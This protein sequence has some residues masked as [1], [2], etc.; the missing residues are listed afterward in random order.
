MEDRLVHVTKNVEENVKRVARLGRN[1]AR[2]G[3]VAVD[4]LMGTDSI[5][6]AKDRTYQGQN[7]KT[8]T[9]SETRLATGS[10]R[11]EL[12]REHKLWINR[13]LHKIDPDP[14]EEGEKPG[15]HVRCADRIA[16]FDEDRKSLDGRHPP[17]K[18]A[19][20]RRENIDKVVKRV[21]GFIGRV[22][23]REE[24]KSFKA[25]NQ[26][27]QNL[28]RRND[29]RHKCRNRIATN[30]AFIPR[31]EDYA[32]PSTVTSFVHSFILRQ[33]QE[34]KEIELGTLD[35]RLSFDRVN[36]ISRLSQPSK[37][38]T[39]RIHELRVLDCTRLGKNERLHHPPIMKIADNAASKCLG[40]IRRE[41]VIREMIDKMAKDPEYV[42][43][44][45]RDPQRAVGRNIRRLV[46]HHLQKI[47]LANRCVGRLSV[48]F[49]NETTHQSGKDHGESKRQGFKIGSIQAWELVWKDKVGVQ[50]CLNKENPA[51][52]EKLENGRV[53]SD[54][55]GRGFLDSIHEI[56][57]RLGFKDKERKAPNGIQGQ[58]SGRAR[59]RSR[60]R[61]THGKP[62]RGRNVESHV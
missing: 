5:T 59:Q 37:A 2:R 6:E 14:D 26:T 51:T 61:S 42:A 45:R 41:S 23:K 8:K 46:M 17:D 13:L 20:S 30:S 54:R 12:G 22:P 33:S 15:V 43:R 35:H 1:K 29:V 21:T 25:R 18:C 27:T 47:I 53:R 11:S 3:E 40:F 50:C 55:G 38:K 60:E 39:P 44:H 58:E 48:M 9:V 24:R 10:R 34:L 4:C 57:G 62:H 19:Q 36:P 28:A 16:N 32:L 56:I 7:K 49:M 31:K 52:D